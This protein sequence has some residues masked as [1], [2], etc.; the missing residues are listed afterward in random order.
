MKLSYEDLT[1]RLREIIGLF[2]EGNLS[3]EDTIRLYEE[4]ASI[5]EKCESMLQEAHLRILRISNEKQTIEEV[6]ADYDENGD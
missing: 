6:T 5:V 1:G 2:E 3:L 4:G